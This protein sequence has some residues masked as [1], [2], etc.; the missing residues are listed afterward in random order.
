MMNQLTHGADTTIAEV[1]DVI[2]F[3][4]DLY[5]L[6]VANTRQGLFAAL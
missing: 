2:C 1:I 6:A 4:A 3:D 5:G